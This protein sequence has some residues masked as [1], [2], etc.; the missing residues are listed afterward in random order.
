MTF[1]EVIAELRRK[2]PGATLGLTAQ[3]G[4]Y[5]ERAQ[6]LDFRVQVHFQYEAEGP[7]G[8]KMYLYADPNT[9]LISCGPKG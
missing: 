7:R 4:A 9:G 3:R 6:S 2:V 1:D 5:F 8:G